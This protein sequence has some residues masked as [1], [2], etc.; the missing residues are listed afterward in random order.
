MFAF[1]WSELVTDTL[2]D[3]L[4]TLAGEATLANRPPL[5]DAIA[6]ILRNAGGLPVVDSDLTD[7]QKTERAERLLADALGHYLSVAGVVTDRPGHYVTRG[8]ASLDA[9]LESRVILDVNRADE[10]SLE[11][12]PAVG[13]ATA[14]AIVRARVEGGYFASIE[15][16][17]DRVDG[18]GPGAGEAIRYATS[19]GVPIGATV[20][21]ET[22][23]TQL[24]RL[25]RRALAG[26]S[27]DPAGGRLLLLMESVRSVTSRMPHPET[28][29]RQPR[30]QAAFQIAPSSEARFVGVLDGAAYYERLPLFL[31]DATTSI[32]VAMFH[33]AFPGPNHPTKALLDELIA[34]KSRGVDVKVVLD[35]DRETDPY[36]SVV[37]NSN[38][39]RYLEDHGVECRFDREEMLLHSKYVVIDDGVSIVGSHNWSAGSY[40]EFDD[41]SFVVQSPEIAAA[42][43]ARFERL[44]T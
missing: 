18:I 3:R 40:S 42:L 38:A 10:T 9:C 26:F 22:Q 33:A 39:K 20:A 44:W 24:S 6:R 14:A 8:T 34:A 30:V 16:L 28:V 25:L 36:M 27:T 12:L 1:T 2:V 13:P 4:E 43:T 11:A 41:L 21:Y 5:R 32:K 7:V 19:F 37:I 17:I 31:R 29:R 35:R 15:E 23:G